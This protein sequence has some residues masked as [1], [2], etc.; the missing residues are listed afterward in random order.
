MD[1]KLYINNTMDIRYW[2]SIHNTIR[3]K[4]IIIIII[5]TKQFILLLQILGYNKHIHKT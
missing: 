1:T 5:I 4:I 3:I 2:P